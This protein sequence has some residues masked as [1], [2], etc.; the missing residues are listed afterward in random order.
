MTELIKVVNTSAVSSTGFHEHRVQ[1][2][3]INNEKYHQITPLYRKSP[4]CYLFS[5]MLGASASQNAA[6]FVRPKRPCDQPVT[7]VEAMK[8][9]YSSAL[10]EPSIRI[11]GKV[12][13]EIGFD[14]TQKHFSQIRE[15]Q[16]IGLAK[17]LIAVPTNARSQVTADIETLS[18]KVKDLDIGHNLFEDWEDVLAICRPM[19]E[20]RSLDLT[21]VPSLKHPQ[22]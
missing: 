10:Q 8:K 18:L 5:Y 16:T 14:Q 15:L 6:S 7:F 17:R 4:S 3:R 12:V 21:Y 9:K 2:S 19:N 11:S 13:E 1:T 20:L 22:I